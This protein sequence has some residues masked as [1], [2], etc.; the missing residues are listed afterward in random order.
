[1]DP[2]T[3]QQTASGETSSSGA[4][5]LQICQEA[6]HAF[7]L[8]TH[9]YQGSL[10]FGDVAPVCT[11]CGL[12]L[13]ILQTMVEFPHCNGKNLIFMACSIKSMDM[14]TVAMSK[15]LVFLNSIGAVKFI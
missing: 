7:K 11:Q 8:V 5:V 15:I 2:Y 9:I 3:G 4:A 12:P 6:E 1:M 10:F 14:I 13:A